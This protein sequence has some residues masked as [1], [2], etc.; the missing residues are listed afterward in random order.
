VKALGTSV[1]ATS[2]VKGVALLSILVRL[3]LNVTF[4]SCFHFSAS[5]LRVD[6]GFFAR[7]V[8]AA[9]LRDVARQ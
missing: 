6:V 4:D 5:G 9:L 3:D 7:E 8:E 2:P 1:D